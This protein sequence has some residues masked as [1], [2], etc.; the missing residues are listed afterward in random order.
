M[1]NHMGA[2]GSQVSQHLQPHSNECGMRYNVV[3]LS[4]SVWSQHLQ[5]HSSEC[6]MRYNVVLLSSSVLFIDRRE[7][8]RATNLDDIRRQLENGPITMPKEITSQYMCACV[9]ESTLK[10]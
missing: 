6:G 5:L 9:C 4:L 7:C 8:S 10:N 1:H 2:K 3:M